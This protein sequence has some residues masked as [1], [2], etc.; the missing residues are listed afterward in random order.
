VFELLLI[1]ILNMQYPGSDNDSSIVIQKLDAIGYDVGYR[2]IT[3]I[4]LSSI[5]I[6]TLLSSLE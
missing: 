5:L 4:S 6:L 3:I 2:Y 1:E